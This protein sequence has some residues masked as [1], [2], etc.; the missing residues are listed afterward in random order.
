MLFTMTCGH[1]SPKVLMIS[2]V[3]GRAPPEAVPPDPPPNIDPP[4]PLCPAI[5]HD[6]LSVMKT[7]AFSE[8]AGV[9]GGSCAG[10][11]HKEKKGKKQRSDNDSGEGVFMK[12]PWDSRNRL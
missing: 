2:A 6:W 3:C 7:R 10:A 8:S 9:F 4:P 1:R 5:D 11:T 12:P